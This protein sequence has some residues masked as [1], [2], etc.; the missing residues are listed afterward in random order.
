MSYDGRRPNVRFEN[1]RPGS[2][3]AG[4][5]E[6]PGEDP[7]TCVSIYGLMDELSDA[8]V[9][10]SLSEMSALFSDERYRGRLVLGGDLNI[11]TQY[12]RGVDSTHASRY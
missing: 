5:L 3:I 7:V 12:P 4:L 2:W 6:V 11:T 8:S 1:S 9:H 10:R